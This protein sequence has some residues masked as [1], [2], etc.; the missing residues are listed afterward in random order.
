MKNRC[1]SPL[2]PS[3]SSFTA[4]KTT[5]KRQISFKSSDIIVWFLISYG[6]TS[7]SAEIQSDR[8]TLSSECNCF[9]DGRC[10]ISITQFTLRPR[11]A[12]QQQRFISKIYNAV[13]TIEKTCSNNNKQKAQQLL[14]LASKVGRKLGD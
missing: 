10:C 9:N 8:H 6:Q 11:S 12:V 14:R 2:R 1:I 4:S 3:A 5:Q 13:I 7:F